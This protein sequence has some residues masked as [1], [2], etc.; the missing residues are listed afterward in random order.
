MAKG[1]LTVNKDD[2]LIVMVFIVMR[3][4]TWTDLLGF[5]FDLNNTFAIGGM[6]ILYFIKLS[7]IIPSTVPRL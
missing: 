7:Y 2:C 3:G 1:H 5:A 6:K 4:G